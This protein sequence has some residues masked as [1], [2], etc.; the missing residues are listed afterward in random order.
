MSYMDL[1]GQ[2]ICW[3]NDIKPKVINLEGNQAREQKDHATHE[4]GRHWVESLE[5]GAFL[6]Q[7]SARRAKKEAELRGFVSEGGEVHV[8]AGGLRV[9][10]QVYV[11]GLCPNLNNWPIPFL[12][13]DGNFVF[14]FGRAF[15]LGR[16][17][18]NKSGYQ[19]VTWT[20]LWRSWWDRGQSKEVSCGMRLVNIGHLVLSNVSSFLDQAL[21]I[22]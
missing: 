14:N 6:Y 21:E 18:S 20:S 13:E 7:P 11:T 4:D 22:Y 17:T 10:K 8:K 5:T 19:K 15:V 3:S 1:R 12:Y 16:S 2:F 9:T